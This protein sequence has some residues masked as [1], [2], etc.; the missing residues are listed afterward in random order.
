M[1]GKEAE[2]ENTLIFH[3]FVL[4]A[5]DPDQNLESLVSTKERIVIM[6][7]KARKSTSAAS[8]SRQ[9]YR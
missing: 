4:T 7:M 2:T 9:V 1:K 8:Y 5:G 6:W 3:H